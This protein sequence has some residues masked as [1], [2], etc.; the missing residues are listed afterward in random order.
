MVTDVPPPDRATLAGAWEVHHDGHGPFG[1]IV[2]RTHPYGDGE[3]YTIS[4][5][6]TAEY[7]DDTLVPFHAYYDSTLRV[8]RFGPDLPV[9]N[10]GDS[11]MSKSDGEWRERNVRIV[12]T[13]DRPGHYR[14]GQTGRLIRP[15]RSGEWLVKMDDRFSGTNVKVTDMA[16]EQGA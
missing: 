5:C 2:H 16:P 4:T 15:D 1:V 12:V 13:R 14:A 8:E 10:E 9:T 7:R 6:N 11:S 3:V